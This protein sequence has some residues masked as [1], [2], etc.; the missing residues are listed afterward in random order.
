LPYW[1][2]RF[3]DTPQTRQPLKT[4]SYE[5]DRFV[6]AL[7]NDAYLR[8]KRLSRELKITPFLYLLSAFAQTMVELDMMSSEALGVPVSS[9][10]K[11]G[12]DRAMGHC[13]NILP[14]RVTRRSSFREY[15]E[16]FRSEY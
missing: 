10:E 12:H 5:G 1:K 8:V 14:F 13:S 3:A 15:V 4:G 6:F 2:T 16:H 7:E 9:R 11:P